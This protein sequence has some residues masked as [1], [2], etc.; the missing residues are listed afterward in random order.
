MIGVSRNVFDRRFRLRG[1]GREFT[2]ANLPMRKYLFI[3]LA[4]LLSGC[5]TKPSD[6]PELY[7]CQVVVL[8]GTTPIADADVIL[9]LTSETLM[10][11]MSG[12]TN[13]SG[14]AVIW[15]SRLNWRGNGAPAGDYIVTIAKP[16]QFE[17]ELSLAEVQA[18]NAEELDK[19]S[20]EQ[21]RKFEALP[22]EVP[23]A[24]SEFGI[25][26]YRMTIS[27]GGENRLEI[28]VSTF[29]VPERNNTR[30]R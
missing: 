15:T 27:K 9:G 20:T 17:G 28:D 21:Q 1:N 29:K 14:V 16:P 30:R 19:Y 25:S 11:S 18:L 2:L 3:L 8:N 22:R 4:F 10:C 5:S 6:V 26:P 23:D 7:P 12:R 24:L 13:S